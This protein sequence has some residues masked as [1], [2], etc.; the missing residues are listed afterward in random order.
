MGASLWRVRADGRTPEQ[1]IESI[2]PGSYAP[3]STK[4]RDRLLFVHDRSDIDFYRFTSP[5]L[6]SP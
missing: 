5:A 2:P 3:A 6:L 4:A 1:R